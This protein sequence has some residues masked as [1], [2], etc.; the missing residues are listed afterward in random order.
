MTEQL[1]DQIKAMG[2]YRRLSPSGQEQLAQLLGKLRHVDL[3]QSLSLEELAYI[4][5]RARLVRYQAGD[6]IIRKGDADRTLY[7]TISGEVRAWDRTEEGKARLLNY[8]GVGDF[9]GE[10]A[11]LED[12]ARAANVDAITDVELVA[13]DREGFERILEYPQIRDYLRS[14]GQQR[15]QVSNRDFE[16]KHWDEITI[17]MAHKSWFALLRMILLPAISFLLATALSVSLVVFASIATEILTSLILATLVGIGL[18]IF[19]AYEDWQNDDLIV[20]SKRIIHI[21]RVLIPPFPI[22]RHEVALNQVQDIVTRR[23]LWTSFFGIQTLAVKTAGT[24]TI[25]F[26]YLADAEW[27]RDEIFRARELAQVRSIGEERSQIRRRLMDELDREAGRAYEPVEQDEEQQVTP[28]A[29]GVLKILDYF[30]PRMRIVRSDRIIWRKHWLI[31][32][33]DAVAPI[34][35]SLFSVALLVLALIRPGFLSQVPSRWVLPLPVGATLFSLLWYLWVYDGWRNDIYIV[36]DERIIDVEGSPFHLKHESRVEG[37][38]DVIQSVDYSSPN[39]LY[40]AFRIGDVTIDTAA[41]R[42]AFTFDLVAKPDKVQQEIFQR[43]TA[44]R[45]EQAREGRERQYAEFSKWFGTYHRSVMEQK[46]Y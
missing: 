39:W 10:I 13:F 36:T 16:G 18:W 19:W 4:A 33:Q 2:R 46:E 5:E 12:K 28:E 9:F 7:I 25:E 3:L 14:W 21:E 34:L 27:I 11:L 32:A 17:V 40:R 20:T 42:A 8:H 22:E 30:V 29:R 44:Y 38:F 41:Q 23:N 1:L 37:T 35:L 43:L 6:L 45:E 24:A 15:I 26:P 31:L